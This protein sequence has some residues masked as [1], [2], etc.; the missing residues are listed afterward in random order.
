MTMTPAG[1]R[2]LKD[3]RRQLLDPPTALRPGQEITERNAHRRNRRS[4]RLTCIDNRRSGAVGAVDFLAKPFDPWM[5]PAKVEVFVELHRTPQRLAD[6]AEALR[7]QLA[8]SSDDDVLATVAR[9]EHLLGDG[10]PDEDGSRRRSASC[11]AC[12]HP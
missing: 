9:V 10:A 11:A 5:L 12:W 3:L 2:L 8:G 7:R 6:Q 1:L 4:R